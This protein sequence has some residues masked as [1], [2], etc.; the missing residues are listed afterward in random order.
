MIKG[1]VRSLHLNFGRPFDLHSCIV[2]SVSPPWDFSTSKSNKVLEVNIVHVALH[3]FFDV[4]HV[5][6]IQSGGQSVMGPNLGNYDC[7]RY[8]FSSNDVRVIVPICESHKTDS[9]AIREL[10]RRDYPSCW[11]NR[12]YNITILLHP[13]D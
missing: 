1:P 5:D 2:R 13:V 11:R 3:I 8:S 12:R 6:A 10:R 4:V 7:N 9:A